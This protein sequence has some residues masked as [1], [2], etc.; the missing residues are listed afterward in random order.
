MRTPRAAPRATKRTAAVAGLLIALSA[1]G[2]D[3]LQP[4][5][6]HPPSIWGHVTLDGEAQRDWPVIVNG[7]CVYT[8][9]EGGWELF[10]NTGGR[11]Q[12]GN[13]I[14]IVQAVPAK[15]ATVAPEAYLDVVAPAGEL[16]FRYTTTPGQTVVHPKT[17]D[18]VQ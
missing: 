18:L 3:M 14:K 5:K 16:D 4:S 15:G 1:S 17:C 9:P 10:G 2:C 6:A 8:A 11:L 12:A 7:V 13:V